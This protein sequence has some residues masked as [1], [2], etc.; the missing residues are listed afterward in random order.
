MPVFQGCSDPH[1]WI[2]GVGR[3]HFDRS[4]DSEEYVNTDVEPATICSEA[5]LSS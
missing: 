1:H 3:D 5:V 4:L 2:V